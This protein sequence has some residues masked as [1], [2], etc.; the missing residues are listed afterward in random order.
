MATLS[1]GKVETE[2]REGGDVLGLL[3]DAGAQ[4]DFICMAGS[5]GTC[6]VR[7]LAGME[8]LAPPSPAEEIMLKGRLDQYRLAC[9]A[10]CLGT[11]DVSVSQR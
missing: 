2:A 9:Q 3:L 10:M 11:G 8:H 4:M 6:R 7:V 1:C 5:C